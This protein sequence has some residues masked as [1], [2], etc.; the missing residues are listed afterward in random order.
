MQKASTI[1]HG[2]R[3]CGMNLMH[4]NNKNKIRKKRQKKKIRRKERI[5]KE[6]QQA[7]KE[8]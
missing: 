7:Q 4:G 5:W 3:K 2:F 6:I 8:F 1:H